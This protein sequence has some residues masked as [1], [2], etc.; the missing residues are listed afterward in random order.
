[1]KGYDP[2]GV[3]RNWHLAGAFYAMMASNYSSQ[4]LSKLKKIEKGN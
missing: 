2:H 1:M 3:K 4:E